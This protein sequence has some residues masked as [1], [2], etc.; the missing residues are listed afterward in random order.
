MA[1]QIFHYARDGLTKVLC[2]ALT[3]QDPAY[4]KRLISQEVVNVQGER[5][6]PLI[7]AIRQ[8]HYKVVKLLVERFG[9]DVNKCGAIRIDST[10][11]DNASPLWVAAVAGYINIVKDLVEAG[12]LINHR[13]ETGSTPIRAACFEGRLEIVQYLAHCGADIEIANA[14]N[15]TCLMIASFR[16]HY[17]TVAFLLSIGADPNK[18]ALC[19]ATAL[20]FAAEFGLPRLIQKL[21]DAGA[22][23]T[24]TNKGFTPVILAAEQAKESVVNLFTHRKE[25]NLSKQEIID[26]FELLGASFA[27]DQKNYN[28]DLCMTYLKMGMVLRYEEPVIPKP[29]FAPVP[30][31]GNRRESQCLADLDA[32]ANDEDAIHMEALTVRERLLGPTLSNEVTIPIVFRGVMLAEEGRY[33]R[34]IALWLHR[35]EL[36]LA[37]DTCVSKDILRFSQMFSRILAHHYQIEMDDVIKVLQA[38]C[39]DLIHKE[40]LIEK[41]QSQYDLRGIEEERD[42]LL[43]STLELLVI[44]TLINDQNLVHPKL[45]KTVYDILKLGV[46][47]SNG[48]ALL[49][50]AT[51]PS[52]RVNAILIAFGV[53]FPYEPLASLLMECGADVNQIDGLKN[54][55]L[56]LVVS[57]LKPTRDFSNIHKI[58]NKLIEKGAHLDAVNYS[59]QDPLQCTTSLLIQIVLKSHCKVHSLKCLAARAVCNYNIDLQVVHQ[60]LPHGLQD[61]IYMHGTGN[62]MEIMPYLVR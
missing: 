49:H 33:D 14:F 36:L 42:T 29:F 7:A 34:C 48:Q 51:D 31:Y 1:L 27:N 22:L 62:R 45:N 59:G 58:I 46:K 32:I 15:N 11:V 47:T 43:M 25:F 16:G 53:R 41:C 6:T 19:G 23:I 44:A 3:D 61:F 39:S 56:H 37:S 20:H 50:L 38:A 55:P 18:K 52:T 12:A 8:G 2:S 54:T 21:L 30:A 40:I 17:D 5:M 26:A 28:L 57:P 10:L 13:T 4:I 35:L 60:N 24:K 9:A